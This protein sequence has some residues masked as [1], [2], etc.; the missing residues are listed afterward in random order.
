MQR[1]QTEQ[2]EWY[3]G[4]RLPSTADERLQ[5]ALWFERTLKPTGYI[6][7]SFLKPLEAQQAHRF[8][9]TYFNVVARR[10]DTHLP[11]EAFSDGHPYGTTN[12]IHYHTPYRDDSGLIPYEYMQAYWMA[13][14]KAGG[15]YKTAKL[16]TAADKIVSKELAR[17][18]KYIVRCSK[19]LNIGE[20]GNKGTRFEYSYAKHPNSIVGCGCPRRS[21]KCRQNKCEG[22]R[23]GAAYI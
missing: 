9:R 7:S 13:M 19:W 11:Y 6:V 10:F 8:L 3:R 21:S 14:L 1:T 16:A 18:T 17:S 22:R 2:L 12:K 23:L 5:I 4:C 20:E 15:I